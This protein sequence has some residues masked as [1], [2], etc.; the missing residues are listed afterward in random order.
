M[1][2]PAAQLVLAATPALHLPDGRC[3][4][5]APRD[6]LLA[7]WLAIEGPTP[8]AR[9]AALLWP[10]AEPGAA[11]NALRQRLFQTEIGQQVWTNLRPV[12]APDFV[13]WFEREV[14]ITATAP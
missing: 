5:L 10:E 13:Q 7:A 3:L 9:L 11:R 1:P 8:R 6:A 4:P 12:Y 2:A 14:G